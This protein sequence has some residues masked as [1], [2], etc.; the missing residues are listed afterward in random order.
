[1]KHI[2]LRIR[3]LGALLTLTMLL[4]FCAPIHAP[5]VRAQAVTFPIFAQGSQGPIVEQIQAWLNQWGDHLLLDGKY[6]PKTAQAVR[7]FQAS[8]GLQ[9]DGVVG[10]LTWR[11]LIIPLGR[12]SH[13]PAVAALQKD[14]RI[15]S[16]HAL[17]VDGVYGPQTE[18]AVK[19]VQRETNQTVD[20]I[21]GPNTWYVLILPELG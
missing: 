18:A 4:V 19:V 14:L 3:L 10:D 2:V 1:M 21:A 13:G 7:S 9:V 15:F 12:G 8:H 17:V 16:S 20:G 6:G 5:S 11:K